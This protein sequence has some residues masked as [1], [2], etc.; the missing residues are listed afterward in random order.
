M[1]KRRLSKGAATVSKSTTSPPA[2]AAGKK[3]SA[4]PASSNNTGLKSNAKPIDKAPLLEQP[5]NTQTAAAKRK[6]VPER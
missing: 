3:N 1:K 5:V 4:G 2:N 6:L